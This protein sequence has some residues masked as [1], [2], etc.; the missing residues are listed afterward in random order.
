MFQ[1]WHRK[2][3]RTLAVS[4]DCRGSVTWNREIPQPTKVK[5][6]GR[7][8]RKRYSGCGE[9]DFSRS[10]DVARTGGGAEPSD[11]AV[12][13]KGELF[14]LESQIAASHGSLRDHK[15]GRH[16]TGVGFSYGA[17]FVGAVDSEIERLRK[18]A[19]D[20]DGALAS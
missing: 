13:I 19:G 3:P 8:G 15:T 9:L 12:R 16:E 14:T 1:R 17:A 6:H 7:D 18:S 10:G 2:G 20:G 11:I 5:G 4:A